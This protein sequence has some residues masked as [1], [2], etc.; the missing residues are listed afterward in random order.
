MNTSL[1][2][3]ETNI[4]SPKAINLPLTCFLIL[5]ATL[6]IAGIGGMAV[7]AL[8][9]KIATT[10]QQLQ[11]TES[12]M[13]R[14]ERLNEELRA[15]IAMLENPT[16]LKMVAAKLGMQPAKLDQ[17]RLMGAPVGNQKNP[18]DVATLRSAERAGGYV[19]NF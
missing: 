12:E 1:P 7:V 15:K 16:A 5:F 19:K 17:Y 8:R 13:V 18:R 10:A 4:K 9:Q 14:L 6:A 2:Y 11:V 3:P